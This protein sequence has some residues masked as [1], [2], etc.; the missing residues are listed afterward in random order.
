MASKAKFTQAPG[1]KTIKMSVKLEKKADPEINSD[2]SIDSGYSR[3]TI[4]P[5]KRENR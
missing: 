4:S 5:D 3:F 2:G 1:R